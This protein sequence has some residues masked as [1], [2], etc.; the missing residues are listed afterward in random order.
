MRRHTLGSRSPRRPASSA[1]GKGFDIPVRL[2][3][4]EEDRRT[5]LQ[6][7]LLRAINIYS[8]SSLSQDL[9]DKLLYVITALEYILLKD[10]SESLQKHIGKRMALLIGRSLEARIEIIKGYKRAYAL[11]SAAVHHGEVLRDAEGVTNFMHDAWH[12]LNKLIGE[13]DRFSTKAELIESIDDL[14]FS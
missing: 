13:S 1:T 9:N 14:K 6:S 4:R 2:L 3:G 5:E 8:K 12:T 11:R 10:S 7:F